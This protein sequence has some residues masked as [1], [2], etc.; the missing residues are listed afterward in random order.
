MR[1]VLDRNDYPDLTMKDSAIGSAVPA[2]K[3]FL[4]QPW[5]ISKPLPSCIAL[6]GGLALQKRGRYAITKAPYSILNGK[7]VDSCYHERAFVPSLT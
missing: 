5:Q 7:A 6:I 4:H 2:P 1:V 3:Q